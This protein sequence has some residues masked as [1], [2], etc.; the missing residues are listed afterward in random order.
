M[1][2]LLIFKPNESN[3]GLDYVF[4]YMTGI[5][6]SA[7]ARQWEDVD[8]DMV[9]KVWSKVLGDYLKSKEILDYALNNLP[10]ERPPSAL[11]FRDLCAKSPDVID[12]STLGGVNKLAYKLEHPP[13]SGRGRWEDYKRQIIELAKQRGLL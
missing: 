8:S 6:G 12:I 5:Y 13:W 1:S 3:D 4:A 9:R 10:S 7:F 11:A 2:N